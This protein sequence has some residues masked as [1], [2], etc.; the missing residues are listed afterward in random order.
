MP[1]NRT[2]PP[3]LPDFSEISDLMLD[4]LCLVDREGRFVSVNA[5]FTRMFGYQAEEVIGKPMVNLIFAPD[6]ERTIRKVGD[7]LGGELTTL[8]ENRWT[9]KDGRV[10]TIMWSARWSE[11]YQVRVAI[12]RDMTEY[13]RGQHEQVAI[14]AISDAAYSSANLTELLQR[15]HHFVGE[16]LPSTNFLVALRD[17]T[18]NENTFPYAAVLFDHDLEACRAAALPLIASVMASGQ[19]ATSE[20]PINCYGAA[21]TSPLNLHSL[22]IPLRVDSESVGALVI[23][24]NATEAEYTNKQKE[25]LQFVAIQ[26]AG[27]I[28]RK[29][30]ETQLQFMAGHDALTQLPN[31]AL[32]I[33]RFKVALSLAQ[34]DQHPL[35][36][37][38]VDLNGFKAINDRHGH[39]CGDAILQ[40]AARRLERC[41]R[42]SDTV[43][44]FGGDEFV[45]LLH[46]SNPKADGVNSIAEKIAHAIREPIVVDGV[47]ISISASVGIACY[48]DHG[49][50]L[51]ELINHADKAMYALKRK[52]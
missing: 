22:G 18:K 34:R 50:T 25:L 5:A 47:A 40:E 27:F 3:K 48:P 35:A 49:A 38:F 46:A 44:R 36:L 41:V 43:T 10:V 51:D 1:E 9:C 21:G 13:K 45:V 4:A 30:M 52:L 2:L 26:I 6:R 19:T 42:A 20:A 24:K 28:Q 16:W 33:D 32:F 15:V 39:L 23:Q 17:D 29:H 14:Y 37:L 11:Q 7:I 12:G 31:R 8:F